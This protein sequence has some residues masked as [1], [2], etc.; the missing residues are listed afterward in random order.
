MANGS[1]VNKLQQ[2]AQLP[3]REKGVSFVLSSYHS[4]IFRNLAFF[5]FTYTFRVGF[6]A[7]L[8]GNGR[9]RVYKNSAHC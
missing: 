4:A 5:E 1:V 8:H 9:M 7:N 2:K 3:L 6:L